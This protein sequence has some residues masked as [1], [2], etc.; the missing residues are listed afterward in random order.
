MAGRRARPSALPAPLPRGRAA[1]AQRLRR[2]RAAR[3]PGRS[4]RVGQRLGAPDP[5]RRRQP[6]VPERGPARSDRAG[7]AAAQRQ[8]LVGRRRRP[9][10]GAGA[11]A[12]RAAGPSRPARPARPRGGGGGRRRRPQ[13]RHA[14]AR[15]AGRSGHAARRALA[16]AA[17]G[18]DRRGAAP[19]VSLLPVPP[20]AGAGGRLRHHH[21]RP[22]QGAARPGRPGAG[23][24]D[25]RRGRPQ[26]A[27]AGASRPAL[28]GGRRRRP[29]R[30][31]PDPGRRRGASALRRPGGDPPLPRGAPLPPADGRRPPLAGDAVQ[32]RAGAPPGVRLS[33]RRG[34]LRRG[35][36]V[37]GGADRPGR[38]D[39]APGHRHQAPDRS[40]A[41]P[42]L[43][44]RVLHDHRARVQR[45]AA[46]RRRSERDAGAGRQLPGLGRRAQLPVPD[47]RL[48]ALERRRPGHRARL[49]PD[50]EPHARDWIP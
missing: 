3:R 29:R 8:R 39:G 49:R 20:R 26:P 23:A 45:P 36:R 21:R 15:A 7:R 34:R 31:L 28:P 32:D 19:P 4:T 12:G 2:Q 17:H 41:R 11:R 38:G 9:A 47:P 44:G 14:A 22:P 25:R 33:G 16:A 43:R 5:A 46:G 42:R 18:A 50:L 24:A 13:V 40:G 1:A 10:G 48:R 37:Q 35:L 6:A 27:A 30:H